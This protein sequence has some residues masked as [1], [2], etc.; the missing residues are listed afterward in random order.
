MY[1][2]FTYI[3]HRIQPNVSV[4]IPYMDGMGIV[5]TQLKKTT[6][7]KSTPSRFCQK[8]Q[9]NH[10]KKKKKISFTQDFVGKKYEEI[11]KSRVFLI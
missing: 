7:L 5:K 1:G 9:K 4:D 2:I 8:K 11:D 3:Y 6:F 10:H